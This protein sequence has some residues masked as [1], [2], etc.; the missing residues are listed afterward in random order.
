MQGEGFA[1]AKPGADEDFEEVGERVVDDG[2]VRRKVTASVGVQQGKF[3]LVG[4]GKGA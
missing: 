3:G 1:F 2:A 4:P